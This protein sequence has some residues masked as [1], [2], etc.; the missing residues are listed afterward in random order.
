MEGRTRSERQAV[1]KGGQDKH[2]KP[3][4]SWCAPLSGRPEKPLLQGWTR[5]RPKA[6]KITFEGGLPTVRKVALR[7]VQP[8]GKPRA[9]QPIRLI[10]WGAAASC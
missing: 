5:E 7:V 10:P 4:A 9:H 6:I 2:G 8:S 3:Q 1:A